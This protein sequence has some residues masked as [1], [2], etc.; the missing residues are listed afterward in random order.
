M[1]DLFT[2]ENLPL[3]LVWVLVV[4]GYYCLFSVI[5]S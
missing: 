4:F 3:T 1:S 5:F 2:F